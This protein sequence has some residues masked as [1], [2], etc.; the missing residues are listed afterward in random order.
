MS[1]KYRAK[2]FAPVVDYDAYAAITA[3]LKA[4]RANSRLCGPGYE[5]INAPQSNLA[6]PRAQKCCYNAQTETLMIVMTDPGVGGY[7]QYTWV[8]YDNI[9]SGLW[10]QLKTMDSTNDFVNDVLDGLPWA[11]T[12]YGKLPRTRIDSFE[13]G[14]QDFN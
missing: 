8:Q 10:E 6:R 7:P 11:R 9:N 13:I 1:D 12:S 14:V 3:A 2:R 5:E 4:D